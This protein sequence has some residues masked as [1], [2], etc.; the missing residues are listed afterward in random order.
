[1]GAYA[2]D[3]K[4]LCGSYAYFSTQTI[5]AKESENGREF[6]KP[7]LVKID[8]FQNV[9]R[10]LG[11]QCRM[12]TNAHDF[13]IWLYLKD[14]AIV[15]EEV[16]YTL[17]PQWL[18]AK[19]CIQSPLGIFTDI[20]I[21]SPSALSRSA[22]GSRRNFILER[23]KRAC[24]LCGATEK[25]TMQHV[26]PY[27]RGGETTSRNL[28]TLCEDCNQDLGT[29]YRP[30]LYSL[31]ELHHGYDPSLISTPMIDSGAIEMAAML[32]NNLMQARCEVW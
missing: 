3:L 15:P 21:I 11:K 14:W 8:G 19:D 6:R 12:V 1:M 5:W 29:E 18:K 32:S 25:L 30:S 22:R 28:V 24:V 26:I 13:K 23:D 17:M 9:L 20:D 10:S 4:L 27:S 7:R 16:A 2:F 31:V